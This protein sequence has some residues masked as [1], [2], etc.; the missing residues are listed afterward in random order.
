MPA[1]NPAGENLSV[2][3]SMQ[4]AA[5]VNTV[6]RFMS[7]GDKFA[8]WIGSYAGMPP[9]AGTMIEPR[10]GGRVR[11]EY[12]GGQSASGSVTAIEPGKRIAM[13]WGYDANTHGMSPGSTAIEITLAANALG[14]LVTLKH[15]G[16]TTAEAQRG[17]FGGWRHYLTMLALRG[18]ETHH[19]DTLDKTLAAYFGA[20]NEHDA[21]KRRALLEQ[22]LTHDAHIQTAWA[23][24]TGID[25]ADGH[26]AGAQMMMPG[27][28]LRAGGPAQILQGTARVK[29]EAVTP[30][31]TA[32]MHGQ[33]II[34]LSLDGRIARLVSFGDK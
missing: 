31:G 17:H 13:T 30:D 6:W 10:V 32:V 8:A 34:D 28:N 24:L 5:S 18:S 12:P 14:T 23:N 11:V 7:E 19:A 15:T 33:N 22:C 27:I 2:V 9:L 26:I 1:S 21:T 20:W 16:I 25:E 3:V 29:W 4:I